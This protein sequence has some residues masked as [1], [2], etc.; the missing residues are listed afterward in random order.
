MATKSEQL[1]QACCENRG[2][3]ARVIS[4]GGSKSADF[5]VASGPIRFIAE[6]K[7][8]D[9]GPDDRTRLRELRTVGHTGGTLKP[10]RVRR[11]IAEAADQLKEYRSRRIPLL[12]VMYDNII[13]SGERP[14]IRNYLF[15]PTQLEWAMYGLHV[16]RL[17]VSG[18]G[19]VTYAGDHR[20]GGRHF[21]S[22][23]R[24]YVSAVSVMTDDHSGINLNVFHNFL[25]EH[26]FPCSFFS[27][28]NDHHF[29]NPSNPL[30]EIVGWAEV[31]ASP[32]SPN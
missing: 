21:Q 1:F 4:P 8:L 13:I 11:A 3:E 7:Q 22:E 18:S 17:N 10:S 30:R 2:Y 27:G 15:Q 20:G 26:P 16:V 9:L 19:D 29:R 24:E 23:D 28:A 32:V 6:V 31:A 5:E 14:L 25:A 12:V